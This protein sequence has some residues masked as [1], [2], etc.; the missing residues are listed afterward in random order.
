MKNFPFKLKG[1]TSPRRL[2]LKN[3]L[4]NLIGDEVVQKIKIKFAEE[5]KASAIKALTFGKKVDTE[6]K[7]NSLAQGQKSK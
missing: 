2:A 6:I 1:A 4:R 7:T 5:A 3:K